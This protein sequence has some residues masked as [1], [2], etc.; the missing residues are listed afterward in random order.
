MAQRA[1]KAGEADFGGGRG[2]LGVTDW[3]LLPFAFLPFTLCLRHWHWAKT[4]LT[5][6]LLFISVLYILC[7]SVIQISVCLCLDLTGRRHGTF[8]NHTRMRAFALRTH[9]QTGRT[10][11]HSFIVSYSI[12]LS[13]IP[14]QHTENLAL[15]HAC[16]LFISPLTSKEQDLP[17]EEE[18]LKTKAI[19]LVYLAADMVNNLAGQTSPSFRPAAW[20]R[21]GSLPALHLKM[22]RRWRRWRPVPIHLLSRS[23]VSGKRN[24]KRENFISTCPYLPIT[25]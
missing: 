22:L 11:V 21:S 15:L 20:G 7:Y 12:I 3:L 5:T 25:T 8:A 4:R 19:Y 24:R 17:Y 9:Q 23:K 18:K 2:Q 1:G 14:G 10:V 16:L 13:R 6:I